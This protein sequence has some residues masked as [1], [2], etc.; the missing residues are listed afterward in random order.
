MIFLSLPKET[1]ITI[2]NNIIELG[3]R[4]GKINASQYNYPHS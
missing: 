1:D 3:Q 4:Q 2:E